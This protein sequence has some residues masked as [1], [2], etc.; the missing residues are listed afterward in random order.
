MFE[1]LPPYAVI[2]LT[3]PS[4]PLAILADDNAWLNASNRWNDS[5]HQMTTL[6]RS[7]PSVHATVMDLLKQRLDLDGEQIGVSFLNGTRR[8]TLAEALVFM[9][10]QPN[11]DL[12]A[13]PE[14][15]I[16]GLPADHPRASQPVS[17]WLEDLRNLNLRQALL[18][19]WTRHWKARSPGTSMSRDQHA[20]QLYRSHFAATSQGGRA[21][22][23]LS[24]EQLD[25]LLS[26]LDPPPGE[27]KVNGHRVYSEQLQLQRSDD[28]VQ[29]LPGALVITHDIRQPVAQMLYLPTHR[30]ALRLFNDR[31]EMERWLIEHQLLLFAI[32]EV[33]PRG[34]IRYSAQNDPL[35]AGIKQILQSWQNAQLSSAL[36]G[37][38]TDIAE[39]ASSAMIRANQWDRQHRQSSFFAPAPELPAESADTRENSALPDDPLPFGSL[40]ADLSLHSRTAALDYQQSALLR[41]LGEDYDGDLND[42]RLKNLKALFDE[43]ETQV[44]ASSVAANELLNRKTVFDFTTINTQ[45]TALYQARL[46][47]L[48]AEI[49]L[50]LKLQQINADEHRLIGAVLDASGQVDWP[51]D[52]CVA[53]VTL[54]QHQTGAGID[55]VQSKVL[56]GVLVFL[57]SNA[58]EDAES[59]ASHLLFWPGSG[60]GVQRYPSRKALE[61]C[62]YGRDEPDDPSLSLKLSAINVNPFEH[63]LQA[64]YTRYEELAAVLRASHTDEAQ[65]QMLGSLREM[66]LFQLLVPDHAV[67]RMAFNQ[68]IEINKGRALASQLP[69][70]ISQLPI[71]SR[72]QLKSLLDAYFPALERADKLRERQ[73]PL[74]VDYS[75]KRVEARLRQDFALEHPFSVIIDL[76]DSVTVTQQPVE[77]GTPGTPTTRL[78]IPSQSRSKLSIQ[79][80]ALLN[81]GE[82]MGLRL[83]FM[84]VE[85]SSDH[86]NERIKLQT[87]IT[88]KYLVN[89]I[90]ALDV[91]GHYQALIQD[92]YL[93]SGSD[94]LFEREYRRECLLKPYQLLLQIQGLSARLLGQIDAGE[95]QMLE[96]AAQ[97][98][99]VSAWNANG[100]QLVMSAA[101]LSVSG[102]D[103]LERPTTL[104]GINF[105]EDRISKRTLL[106]LP[107]SP[108]RVFVRRYDS[109]ESARVALFNLC[110]RHEKMRDYLADR[111]LKGDRARH[112]ARIAQALQKNFDGLIEVGD[113]WPTHTSLAT[114]LLNAEMGRVIVAHQ[115]SSTSNSELFLQKQATKAEQVFTYLK[116][117]ISVLPIFGVL[118]AVYDLWS[119]LNEAVAAFRKGEALRGLEALNGAMLAFID[120][121]MDLI[122]GGAVKKP[123][124]RLA[125]LLRAQQRQPSRIY[126]MI[127]SAREARHLAA[128]F[129]GYAHPKELSLAALPVATEGLY[130]N[131]YRH[132]DGDFILREGTLYKVQLD[133]DKRFWRLS[134]TASK[135]YRQPVALDE[136]GNWDTFYGVYGRTIEGGGAG[137]GG[138]LGRVADTLEPIWPEALRERLPRWWTDR[139][140]RRYQQ[141]TDESHRLQNQLAGQYQQTNV[142]IHQYRDAPEQQRIALQQAAEAACIADINIG[143]RRYQTLSELLPFGRGN[144]KTEWLQMRS[145]TALLLADRYRLRFEYL[146]E[147]A[148]RLQDEIDNLRSGLDRS[149]FEQRL[150]IQEQVRNLRLQSIRDLDQITEHVASFD[151]WFKRITKDG[152]VKNN[153]G[154][155]TE[156]IEDFDLLKR[157]HEEMTEAYS[158]ANLLYFKTGHLIQTYIRFD[159]VNDVS[160]F[161]LI[162][163]SRS[164]QDKIDRV[165]FNQY[166][167]GNGGGVQGRNLVLQN[168]LDIYAEFQRKM[169]IWSTSY[170]QHFHADS[171]EAFMAGVE[172]MAERARKDIVLP[173]PRAPAGQPRKQVFTTEDGLV[174]F[175]VEEWV[176][177]TQPR[178]Y[179]LTGSKGVEEI[180]EQASDGRFRQLNAPASALAPAPTDVPAL[181]ADAKKRLAAAPTYQ[182]KVQGY[183]E[184]GMLPVDLEHMMVSEADELTRRALRIEQLDGENAVIKNL[185]DKA[186][187][188]KIS[189][190]T[191]RTEYS[192]NSKKPTDGMLD[193]LV[194]QNAVEIRKPAAVKNLGKRNDGRS[195]FLQ[196]YEI[197]DLKAQPEKLLWYAHFHYTNA[198]PV[199]RQFEKAH[200]KLPEHQFLTH[201]D[202]ASLPYADIGK[203]SAVLDHF[204]N[205]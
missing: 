35:T 152:H 96:T 90:K 127:P 1:K 22:R 92:T 20:S 70:S 23:Y 54:S 51:S 184:Q 116:M 119:N 166:L 56:D 98:S 85:I 41:L 86:E 136:N 122:P 16:N 93:G 132:A 153:K 123:S 33:D 169:K 61:Q 88:G 38:G 75:C 200:L 87:G 159:S 15:R 73:L 52:I 66:T 69:D 113:P 137:G 186:A 27:L 59:L 172:K 146:K 170:P 168:C 64:Q 177:A 7:T 67:R 11:L 65:A 55:T 72:A 194:R 9:A 187:E 5:R 83:G 94:P 196:E 63:S 139:N 185:R 163:Q 173:A 68:L 103:T 57:P 125:A 36:E 30:P 197:W 142:K 44:Q 133:S 32:S 114:H 106:Y 155:R 191:L 43:L 190:R 126:K 37:K 12:A 120:G 158:E 179:R 47:G 141:L 131:V 50:Q 195:D 118:P 147:R 117:A 48:R 204:D 8:C 108:D 201:A 121:M 14:C 160:W 140:L 89:I 84:K 99:T 129:E 24:G 180:W 39:H 111:A 105:I 91:A 162:H 202:D 6:I 19:S 82:P 112:K 130:R 134:E 110:L 176:D 76:P 81:V 2:P 3:A 151:L 193:D 62:L 34:R 145:D 178:R 25:V 148:L 71:E 95:Q 58:L 199:F 161:Y 21:E 124:A 203:R 189:G 46:K 171:L 175:G 78:D 138:V 128:R 107:D 101:C 40:A 18:Q 115:Q 17:I 77:G 174:L 74:P 97:A 183:A 100:R 31:V 188:L 182:T 154:I 135:K 60:G 109:L 102:P 150:V 165:L 79:Q 42:E 49:E 45:Y 29:E 149:N 4:M 198:N 28:S 157:A 164:L 13:L 143:I 192:L 104:S 26:V 10:Q 80:L 167:L 181:V 53:T 156:N 144:K 205:L